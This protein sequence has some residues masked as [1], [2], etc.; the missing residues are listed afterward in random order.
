MRELGLT[1]RET[2]VILTLGIA[3]SGVS[4]AVFGALADALNKHALI[5]AICCL[6]AAAAHVGLYLTPPV[7]V[8]GNS[9]VA[10]EFTARLLCRENKIAICVTLDTDNVWNG[11]KV[12]ENQTGKPQIVR[13]QSGPRT[14]VKESCSIQCCSV[15]APDSRSGYQTLTWEQAMGEPVYFRKDGQSTGTTIWRTSEEDDSASSGTSIEES[16]V[17]P[18]MSDSDVANFSRSCENFTNLTLGD[19]IWTAAFDDEVKDCSSVW[20]VDLSSNLTGDSGTCDFPGPTYNM[21]TLLCHGGFD[22]HSNAS[23]MDG[24][25]SGEEEA[26]FGTTFVFC[27]VFHFAV[28]FFLCPIFSIADSL[29]Y[30]ILGENGK[31]FGQVRLWG[32]FS[33]GLFAMLSGLAMDALETAGVKNVYLYPFVICIFLLLVTGALSSRIPAVNNPR[34]SIPAALT[35]TNPGTPLQIRSLSSFPGLSNGKSSSLVTLGSQMGQLGV[36]SFQS[37]NG[38]AFGGSASRESQNL[39]DIRGSAILIPQ[40]DLE[41]FVTAKSQGESDGT[42]VIAHNSK[43]EFVST[44]YLNREDL[45]ESPGL[46]SQNIEDSVPVKYPQP[47]DLEV[48]VP[49]N[50]GKPG[51]LRDSVPLKRPD[52]GSSSPSMCR[53]FVLLLSSPIIVVIFVTVLVAGVILGQHNAFFFWYLKTLGANQLLLGLNMV[54]CCVSEIALLFTSGR[55]VQVVGYRC[56]LYIVF[57]VYGVRLLVNSFIQNPWAAIGTEVTASLCNGLLFPAASLCVNDLAPPGMHGTVQGIIGALHWS[58]G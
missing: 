37:A 50:S 54:V 30:A 53:N 33:L 11:S 38:F 2:A 26:Q 14:E 46:K 23:E 18:V 16:P 1:P 44:K 3:G 36:V 7:D 42:F 40:R 43:G 56:C 55:I 5:M 48:S 25:G 28:L 35:L 13:G 21:C 32:T 4:R 58:V 6:V 41:K 8:S 10:H 51:H 12:V 17:R 19:T 47:V 27:I 31:N 15:V 45:G 34:S 20:I 57:A 29:V 9:P 52:P 39:G 22:P 24:H 49:L